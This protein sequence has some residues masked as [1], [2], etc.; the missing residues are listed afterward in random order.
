MNNKKWKET[1]RDGSKVRIYAEDGGGKYPMHSAIWSNGI[2]DPRKWK[3]NGRFS[4]NET[5]HPDDLMPERREF[6]VNEYPCGVLGCPR[7]SIEEAK[8]KASPDSIGVIK[9]VE[10][11]DNE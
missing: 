4:V 11:L 3:A 8:A 9:F 1:T 6:W 7:N 5:Y 2:W 10:A